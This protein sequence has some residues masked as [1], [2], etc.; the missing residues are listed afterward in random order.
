MR[1]RLEPRIALIRQ[2]LIE[3]P[4]DHCARVRLDHDRIWLEGEKKFDSL[5]SCSS[6]STN[7]A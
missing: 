3:R 1:W 2:R 5:I 7:G 6:E 4:G